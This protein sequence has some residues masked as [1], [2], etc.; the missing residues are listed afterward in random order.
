[1][2]ELRED[3]LVLGIDDP[4]MILHILIGAKPSMTTSLF[5]PFLELPTSKTFNPKFGRIWGH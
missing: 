2:A 4:S 3:V 5:L 1:M